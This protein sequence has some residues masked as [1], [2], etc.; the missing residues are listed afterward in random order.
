MFFA[1]QRLW[2]SHGS[3]ARPRARCS[4][5]HDLTLGIALSFSGGAGCDFFEELQSKDSASTDT[6]GGTGA[7]TDGGTGA[8]TDGGTGADTDGGT[9]EPGCSLEEDDRCVDQDQVTRCDL[10]TGET[11][12]FNCQALCGAAL[13]LA[14][15]PSPSG[16][17]GCWCV[18][19][20]TQ[21]VL[22]CRELEG[23]LSDC[24]TAAIGAPCGDSCLSRAT[25]ETIRSYG[26]LLNCAYRNCEPGCQ[27]TPAS[28]STC[29]TG[30][31]GGISGCSVEASVCNAD[32]NDE[33]SWP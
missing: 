17:H 7:D 19:P 8:D 5:L 12:S 22:A 1:N 25:P 21:P 23:C 29:L 13:N 2:S 16:L 10:D 3:G 15:I 18:S 30:A 14:C 6:D 33:P 4:W 27:S 20:G 26:A 24:G 28:C 32:A 11:T 9:G 31:M